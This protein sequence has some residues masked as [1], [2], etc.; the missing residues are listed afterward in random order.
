MPPARLPEQHDQPQPDGDDR[1]QQLTQ[2]LHQ[3]R[4]PLEQ[5]LLGGLDLLRLHA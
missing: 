2:A 5:R 1:E 4:M 3:R